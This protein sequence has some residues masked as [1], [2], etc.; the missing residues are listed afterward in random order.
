MNV[1]RATASRVTHPS[2]FS[3]AAAGVF[4]F[5]SASDPAQ[6]ASHGQQQPNPGL[7]QSRG[8]AFQARPIATHTVWLGAGLVFGGYSTL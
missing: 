3:R 4:L 1:Q 2:R 5:A 8:V 7:S 6:A